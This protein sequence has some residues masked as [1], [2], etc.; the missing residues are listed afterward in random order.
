MGRLKTYRR[1]S[2][3]KVLAG[4]FLSLHLT[5]PG[6]VELPDIPDLIRVTVDH[7]DHG[8]LIQWEPSNDPDIAAY[9]VYS[10][11]DLVFQLVTEVPPDIF[12]YKHPGDGLRNPAFSVTA[13]DSSDNESLFE[14]NVHRAV[15]AEV[16]FDPCTPANVITWD[17]YEGWEGNISAY[18]I[19]G[20]EEGGS[21]SQID[22]VSASDLEYIHTEIT[23]GTRYEYYIATVHTSGTISLSDIVPVASLYPDPPGTLELD[24]VSVLGPDEVEIIFSADTGGEINDFRIMKRSQPGAPYTEVAMIVDAGS[25]PLLITD[26]FPTS[27]DS[28]EFL[29]QSLYLAPSCP[30]PIVLSESN[31]G[32]N[33]LLTALTDNQT[34]SLNWT[35]YEHFPQGL[36]G[37]AIERK[38]E[39]GEFIEIDRVGPGT[40]SWNETLSTLLDGIQTGS[41]EYR[42]TALEGN[43]GEGMSRSN[44]TEVHVETSV[45]LPNAFTPGSNDMNFEFRPVFDF[46]PRDYL[47]IV[48]DRAGRKLFETHDPGQGW[49][50]RAR[51]GDFVTEG[52]YVY[53]IQ[54]TDYTGRFSTFT[55]NVTVLY[56]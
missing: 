46:A 43:G 53:H 12:E 52:V 21:F 1:S 22:F 40:T 54:M 37:Y 2:A 26:Q 9:R 32:N 47:M 34:V 13:L 14:D 5:L 29:I 48:L 10:R 16:E 50:G 49:D 8:F 33:V 30:D 6:Q 20:R 36:S 19:Y 42:I 56:P 35:S 31:P 39:N 11:Q 38:G 24:Q 45:R 55:G 17:P 44:V 18:Q 27:A 3:A 28:Y 25:S 41:L 15:A 51:N 4:V 23:V 7:T